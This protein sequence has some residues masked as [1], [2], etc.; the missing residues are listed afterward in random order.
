MRS[1]P[2][3]D[4]PLPEGTPVRFVQANDGSIWLRHED[5]ILW[6]LDNGYGE[7]AGGMILPGVEHG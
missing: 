3:M 2:W 6:L 7:L 1:E 5:V 4:G